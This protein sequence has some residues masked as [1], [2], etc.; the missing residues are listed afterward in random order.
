MTFY[1]AHYLSQQTSSADKINN[2]ILVIFGLLIAVF[3][4]E[5]VRN[6]MDTRYRDLLIMA[7]LAFLFLA[8]MRYTDYQ[9]NKAQTSSQTQMGAFAKNFAKEHKISP[10]KVAFNSTSLQDGTIIKEG[11]KF[12][13]L[14]LSKDQKTYSVTQVYLIN[15]SDVE[16]VK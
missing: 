8:G 1:S 13:Q 11:N 2:V 3:L 4:F 16:V 6:G 12:Y 14:S 5:M 15:S 9:T 7:L 10:E